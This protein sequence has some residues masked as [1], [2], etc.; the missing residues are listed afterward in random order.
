MPFLSFISKLEEFTKLTE[1]LKGAITARTQK[2]KFAKR[3]FLLKPGEVCEYFYF[4]EKGLGR[5]YYISNNKEFS[6]DISV[7]G[8][9][10]GDFSSF[11]L[12]KPSEQY[13]ELLEDSELYFMHYDDL[14]DLYRQ[15]HLMETLG[16]LIAERHYVSLF[17]QAHSLK[18]HTTT[19]R[20][21]LLFE[22]KIEIVRRAPIGVIA[23]YLGMSIEN[24]SRI[25]GK[26]E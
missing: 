5:V 19:E 18:F 4:I 11:F 8:E 10:L 16:R 7:D 24:L 14:Q 23:S 3:T 2:E 9:F 25:R 17:T 21:R 13:I 26:M 20:Y 12:Q 15:Y 6:T 1:E 22:R